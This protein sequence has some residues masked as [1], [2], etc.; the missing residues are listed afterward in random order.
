MHSGICVET[1]VYRI[2][3]T[4]KADLFFK[5]F[6]QITVESHVL[7]IRLSLNS[8]EEKQRDIEKNVS[9]QTELC[10]L[11]VFIPTLYFVM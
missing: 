2:P 9:G 6:N 11:H 3:C 5:A 1:C 8:G 4:A 7:Y 10:E